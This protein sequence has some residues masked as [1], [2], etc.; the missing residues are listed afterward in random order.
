[1]PDKDAST[2]RVFLIRHGETEWSQS[3]RH[4]GRTEVPLTDNGE[5]QIKALGKVV[6]GK[7]KLIDPAKLVKVWVSPRERTIL[8]YKLLSGQS[9]GYEVVQDVEEWVYGYD[10]YRCMPSEC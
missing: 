3:G 7:G 1:M 8:T 5:A 2:P 6:Y 10:R 9:E 4:T